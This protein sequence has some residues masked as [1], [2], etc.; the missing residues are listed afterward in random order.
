MMGVLQ[1]ALAAKR[2]CI[3]HT[4]TWLCL[5]RLAEHATFVERRHASPTSLTDS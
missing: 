1:D 5:S 3:P 4:N 2:L